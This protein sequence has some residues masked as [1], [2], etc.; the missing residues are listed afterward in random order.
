MLKDY[1]TMSDEQIARLLFDTTRMWRAQLNTVLAQYELT[2]SA[3]SVIRVLRDEGQ[4]RTQK[5]LASALAIE[6]PTLVKL[7]DSLERLNWIERRVAPTDRRAKTI[8]LIDSALPQIKE[9]DEKLG[10]VRHAILDV[11][12]EQERNDFTKLLSKVKQN[13][14]QMC[15]ESNNQGDPI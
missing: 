8:W 5:E 13:L 4:G 10:M 1:A 14:E 15:H 3:W 2:A 9:A 6:G 7:L 11:L 12:D